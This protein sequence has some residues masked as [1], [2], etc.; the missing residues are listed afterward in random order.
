MEAVKSK[1][2]NEEQLTR[3]D[4]RTLMGMNENFETLSQVMDSP[5]MHPVVLLEGRE[6]LGKRH[7]ATW[8][9]ARI[10]CQ[11]LSSKPCGTCG[12]CREVIAGIHP[13]VMVLDCADESIKTADVEVLQRHFDMLSSTGIRIGLIFNADRM[14]TEAANRALKT[15]EEPSDQ[16][17]IIL[18]SS[19]PA[20][21]P[22][23]VRGRCMRWKVSLPDRGLT[24]NWTKELLKVR[25]QSIS[26]Q[27]D[28]LT[29]AMRNGF[30]PG[31]I[32]RELDDQTDLHHGMIQSI[33]L[34]LAAT[35]PNQVLQAAS[36]LARIHKIKVPDML[37]QLEW[38]LSSRYRDILTSKRSLNRDEFLTM[39]RR[40]SLLR[41]IR[42]R[43]VQ[44]KIVLNAQL[45]AESVGL[46]A[47]GDSGL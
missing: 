4:W 20:A 41:R 43:A 9:S 18:T 15:L 38:Q 40:R 13:D 44:G 23:T 8:M 21:L 33:K 6:G 34:L 7:L 28:I 11:N 3:M 45:V 12:S 5:R 2:S 37:S 26:S 1:G 35:N 46:C 39:H 47:W 29:L 31:M 36:D 30:S 19:R 25:G 16:V 24:L 14:T 42:R 32:K 27:D 22:A 10:L 17:R